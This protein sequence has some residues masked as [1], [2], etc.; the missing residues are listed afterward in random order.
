MASTGLTIRQPTTPELRLQRAQR[1]TLREAQLTQALLDPQV[2]GLLTLLGGLYAAQQI[3]WSEDPTRRDMIT[4]IATGGV[5]L[6]AI[7]RAGM[8]GWPALAAA[9]VSGAVGL[10]G[11]EGATKPPV[12]IHWKDIFNAISPWNIGG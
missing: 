5:V 12:E 7:S 6:M 4:G 3:P 8:T 2:I 9:G 11:G 1:R 10:E